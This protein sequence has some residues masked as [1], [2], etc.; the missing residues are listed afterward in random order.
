MTDRQIRV[1]SLSL[2]LCGLVAWPCACSSSSKAG[3]QAEQ[4][5]GVDA[6]REDGGGDAVGGSTTTDGGSTVTDGMAGGDAAVNAGD[7]SKAGDAGVSDAM[8][9][10]TADSNAG[11]DAPAFMGPPPPGPACSKTSTW[12]SGVLVSIS[13]VSDSDELDAVTPDELT[14]VWTL[15]TGNARTLNYA[16]RAS[17]SDAFSAPQSLAAGQFIADRSAI[18]PDG[19]RLIVVNAD[20]QGFSELTRTSRALPAEAFGAPATG[21]FTNL[22]TPGV[23]T[24][25]QSYGDPV[26]SADDTVFY[27]SVYGGT[28]QTQT[29]FRA[30]RLLPGDAWSDGAPL[31]GSSDLAPQGSLRRRP[32]GISADKQT[33]FIWDEVSS[34]E[35]AGWL[36]D[37]T[38]SFDSFVDLG[39]RSMAAPNQAC[40]RLYYSATGASSVDVFTTTTQ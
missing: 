34:F 26:V 20:G 12:A 40:N 1:A 5:S 31:L 6:G 21:S 17:T 38:G 28:G 4:E 39:S 14:I 22:D 24:N 25:G 9:S 3:P 19:L 36:N 37:S 33:L 30:A 27:Y 13:S 16:D 2:A 23:L 32:T 7:A 8:T 18:S 11:D 29:I 10:A 15:G 35:R